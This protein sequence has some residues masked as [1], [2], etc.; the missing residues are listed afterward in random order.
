MQAQTG[1]GK[2]LSFLIPLA[3]ILDR[4]SKKVQAIILAPSRELVTQI[5]SVGDK[6]FENTNIRVMPIIGGA[7]VRGQIQRMRDY[8]PQVIIATPGR[9]AEIVFGL[10][11]LKL[12]M[13]KAVVIDEVDNMLREPYTGEIQTILEATPIF[14]RRV[15]ASIVENV[16]ANDLPDEDSLI[17]YRENDE[18]DRVNHEQP[19]SK[20]S[21]K[22]RMVCFASAT[23]SSPLVTKFINELY[24]IHDIVNSPWKK[25]SLDGTA[26]LPTTINHGLISCPRIKALEMLKKTIKSKPD[27]RSALIFVNDPHRVEIVCEKLL[28]M[29]IIAAPLHGDTNK[30]DRKDILARLRDGRLPLVVTTELAARGIDIPNLTHVINFELPTDAQHYVHR[31]GR[32][33]R[34]GRSGLVINFAT[35]DTKF[36]IRRFGKQLGIKVRDCELR[37]GHVHLKM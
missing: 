21:N 32:C 29:G 28:E 9:L 19:L 26:S 27:V 4:D 25:I 6:L 16:N 2:T 5:A 14:K 15:D 7:N 22:K 3:D 12:G 13:I 36:V 35:P 33:G 23:G 18:D 8:R 30:D 17:N 37:E 24:G 11:K 1:S 34:A 31:A 20:L 10:E